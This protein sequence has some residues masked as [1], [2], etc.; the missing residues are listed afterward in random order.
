ME[1]YPIA[2]VTG[3]PGAGKSATLA[4]FLALKSNYVAFDIDWLVE[5]T[6]TL[7]GSD[8]RFAPTLWQPYNALWFAILHAICLN[9][10]QSVLFAPFDK[11]DIATLGQPAWCGE[12][13]WLLLDCDDALRRQ[14]LAQ[15]PDWTSAMIE[16]AI[17]DAHILRQTV[18]DRLDTGHLPP[19]AVALE[20]VTWLQR[21]G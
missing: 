8:I 17:T 1:R 2:I 3:A 6:S 9:H 11:N 7:V 12:L 5:P 20:I 18:T 14:R 13:R 10:Q 19:E 21:A 16:E 4:A 15:R